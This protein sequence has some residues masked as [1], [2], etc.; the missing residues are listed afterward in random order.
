MLRTPQEF[1]DCFNQDEASFVYY[2]A[3]DGHMV[4][5]KDVNK[6]FENPF[7]DEFNEAALLSYAEAH[8]IMIAC[9]VFHIDYD[10]HIGVMRTR[11]VLEAELD[12]VLDYAKNA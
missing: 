5:L 1:V 7:T 11:V 3:D 4:F 10:I 2:V 12:G 6:L 9:M 8:I